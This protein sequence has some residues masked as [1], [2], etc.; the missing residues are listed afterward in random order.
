M[1]LHDLR[2]LALL[3]TRVTATSNSSIDII[4]TNLPP[5]KLNVEVFNTG[6]LDHTGQYCTADLPKILDNSKSSTYSD[7]SSRNLNN[8]KHLLAT[9]T[10]ENVTQ[11]NNT[12]DAYDNFLITYTRALDVAC[13]FKTKKHHSKRNTYHNE[14][15]LSLRKEFIK[16]QDK[17]N[18]TGRIEDKT[19]AN[20]KKK[21]YDLKLQE[22]RKE[23][24]ADYINQ[25]NNKI[26]AIWE[27]INRGRAAKT[28]QH[29][30]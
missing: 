24:N 29:Q 12:D 3:P 18:L 7:T 9:E 6:L 2:R 27:I 16:A 15:A 23:A 1:N 14:E 25:A 5:G 4:C 28:K 19:E 30:A 17:F 26:K 11:S 20:R 22:L 8:L 21:A 13:T 10:W